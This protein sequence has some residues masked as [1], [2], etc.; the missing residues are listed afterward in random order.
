MDEEV[1]GAVRS[2]PGGH[3]EER[4]L[5]LPGTVPRCCLGSPWPPPRGEGEMGVYLG[6][7]IVYAK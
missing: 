4:H 2:K 3:L 5:F 6:I 1:A 7:A